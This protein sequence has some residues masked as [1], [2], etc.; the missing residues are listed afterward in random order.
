MATNR[1]TAE[2]IVAAFLAAARDTDRILWSYADLSTAIGRPGQHRLLGGPL[3]EVRRLCEERAWPDIAT[4]VVT[5][6]SLLDGTLRPSP[7]ALVE[8]PL[9]MR[10]RDTYRYE[11]VP[12]GAMPRSDLGQRSE[13]D[14][15]AAHGARI[16]TGAESSLVPAPRSGTLEKTTSGDP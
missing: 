16:A 2:A 6:D 15:S 4:V 8:R 5:K 7:Q 14:Y 12:K 13:W 10:R 1:E 9:S 11:T 3:D